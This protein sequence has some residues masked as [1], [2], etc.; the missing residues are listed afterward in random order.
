MGKDE[1]KATISRELGREIGKKTTNY[2]NCPGRRGWNEHT[3]INSQIRKRTNVAGGGGGGNNI[4]NTINE[5]DGV[6]V[7]ICAINLL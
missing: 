1:L 3:T 7:F 4:N 5:E 2:R 6:V